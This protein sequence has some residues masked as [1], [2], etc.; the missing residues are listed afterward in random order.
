MLKPTETHEQIASEIYQD[1]CEGAA[2]NSPFQKAWDAYEEKHG[3]I[4][5][6]SL[7]ENLVYQAILYAIQVGC[8]NYYSPSVPPGM[9]VAVPRKVRHRTLPMTG[10]VIQELETMPV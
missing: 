9:Q 8:D 5:T 6:G 7:E 3:N 10:T 2:E 1:F 4:V